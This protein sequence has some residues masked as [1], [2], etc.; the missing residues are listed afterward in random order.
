M[1][2]KD[3]LGACYLEKEIELLEDGKKQTDGADRQKISEK[4]SELTKKRQEILNFIMAIDDP[5]T[6]LIAELRCMKSLKWNAVA[7]KIGGM[8]SEYTV[9][10]RFYRFLEKVGA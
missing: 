7:D 3:L 9:K 6:R 1:T 8:N 5:Q 4:I 10:K 2:K